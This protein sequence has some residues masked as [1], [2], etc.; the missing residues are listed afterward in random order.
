MANFISHE[1]ELPTHWAPY[2]INGDEDSL[3]LSEI[4]IIDAFVKE[5]GLGSP[6][7]V[8]EETF[9]LK[10]HDAQ[11]YG[12]LASDCATYSF[13]EEVDD[14]QPEPSLSAADRNPSMLG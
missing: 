11:N 13:L 3:T 9:F 8:G 5:T 2:L 14:L 10:Y 4:N 1:F 6:V 7:A 12:V